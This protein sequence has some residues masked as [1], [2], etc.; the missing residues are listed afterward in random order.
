MFN[1]DYVRSLKTI[2]ENSLEEIYFEAYKKIIEHYIL[3]GFTL[4]EARLNATEITFENIS[5]FYFF[6]MLDDICREIYFEEKFEP[7][8]DEISKE[9]E[10]NGFLV[11]KVLRGHNQKPNYRIKWVC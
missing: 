7:W 2:R 8:T 5:N 11:E 6:L 4:T 9:L 1:V 3:R 10:K